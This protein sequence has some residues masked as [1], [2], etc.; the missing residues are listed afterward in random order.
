MARWRPLARRQPAG[1]GVFQH[2][3]VVRDRVPDNIQVDVEVAVRDA[4]AHVADFSPRYLLVALAELV[5]EP[6]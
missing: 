6:S 2:G 5:G 3:Q 1:N 4:F